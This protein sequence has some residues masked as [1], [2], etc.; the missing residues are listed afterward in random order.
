MRYHRETERDN[1]RCLREDLQRRPLPRIPSIEALLLLLLLHRQQKRPY[2]ILRTAK[3]RKRQRD[4]EGERW[5][6]RDRDRWRERHTEIDGERDGF[7]SR[8]NLSQP[9]KRQKETERDNIYRHWRC[10]CWC[11]CWWWYGYCN[12]QGLP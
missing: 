1:D 5:R 9:V 4:R 3:E 11:C 7:L 6:E 2:V 12:R 10:W 8:E